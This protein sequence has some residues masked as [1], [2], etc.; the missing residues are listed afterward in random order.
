VGELIRFKIKP[1]PQIK[2]TDAE[3]TE[4]LLK[5]ISNLNPDLR[6]LALRALRWYRRGLL[7]E[8][9]IDRFIDYWIALETIG[10]HFAP[11]V[12]PTLKVR[13]TLMRH[14]TKQKA[15]DM[16]DLRGK[17]FHSGMEDKVANKCL[18]L[19]ETIRKLIKEAVAKG[20]LGGKM[21]AEI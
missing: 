7:D 1:I 18:Q 8:D 5:D 13:Q 3:C 15:D 19:K 14:I 17:L 12:K 4:K 10:N 11:K 20:R 2:K 6:E 16:I 9:P 21:I